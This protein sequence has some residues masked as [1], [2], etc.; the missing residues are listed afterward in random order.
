MLQDMAVKHLLASIPVRL[1]THGE[2]VVRADDHVVPVARAEPIV[3]RV[4]W[5]GGELERIDVIVK[6]MGADS[7]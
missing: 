3:G 2:R 1:K 5:L 7:R 4:G 6:G